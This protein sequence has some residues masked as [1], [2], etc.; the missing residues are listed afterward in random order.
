MF[1]RLRAWFT[2]ER[3]YDQEVR[4]GHIRTRLEAELQHEQACQT[5]LCQQGAANFNQRT[6]QDAEKRLNQL[7]N[8]PELI[9]DWLDQTVYPAIGA[10]ARKAGMSVSEPR[11][12]QAP[13]CQ[14]SW[15]TMDRALWMLLQNDPELLQD[16]VADPQ[17]VLA[18]IQRLLI[19]WFD[20]SPVW[21]KFE[22][23]GSFLYLKQVL[24]VKTMNIEI[25]VRKD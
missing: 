12:F 10:L 13:K 5:V 22:S 9:K 3:Q 18:N 2:R 23:F 1:Y 4:A 24:V 20:H 11:A 25:L 14:L 7:R 16:L 21:I 17:W 8:S 6:L 19:V 15:A